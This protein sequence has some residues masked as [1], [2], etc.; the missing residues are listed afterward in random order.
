MINIT[1]GQIEQWRAIF[2]YPLIRI[3]ALVASAPVLGHI[4][5][6]MRVKVGLALVVTAIIAPT[7]PVSVQALASP[8]GM[9]LIAAQILIGLAMGFAL[10]LVISAIELA[11]ELIGTQM[12]L[13]F[14]GFFDPQTASQGTSIGAWLGLLA[15]LLLLCANGHLMMLGAVADSFRV[16]PIQ[17]DA[18]DLTN[19]KKLILFGGELFRI[20]LYVA[21]PV[22][23]A[24]LV[25]NI[26]LGVLARVAPQL[27]ILAIGFPVTIMVGFTM[28][29]AA[30][31]FIMV[32]LDATIGRALSMG[33]GIVR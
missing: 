21:L 25:C 19:W 1:G 10:R 15:T 17:T 4:G 2:F 22:L 29:L 6:P 7:L 23:G 8:A 24:M 16:I 9:M 33:A 18:V 12:G 20:G 14:A 13:N 5:V 11:G 31:P 27:N 26:G 3:L 30:L 28:L 32:Y